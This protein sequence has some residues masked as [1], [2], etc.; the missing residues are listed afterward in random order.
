MFPR[1]VSISKHALLISPRIDI[2]LTGPRPTNS[3]NAQEQAPGSDSA[4]KDQNEIID[5]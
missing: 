5:M 4:S 3:S 2:T 1:D